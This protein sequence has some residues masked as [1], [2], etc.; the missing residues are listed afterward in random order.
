VIGCA[1]LCVVCS[2]DVGHSTREVEAGVEG[3]H[4]W[5]AI[6]S[7]LPSSQTHS[8][9]WIRSHGAGLESVHGEMWGCPDRFPFPIVLLE[10]FK[11]CRGIA[12]VFTLRG[13]NAPLVRVI[14]SPDSPEAVTADADGVIKIWDIRCQSFSAVPAVVLHSSCVL[15]CFPGCSRVFKRLTN[16]RKMASVMSR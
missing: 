9:R 1:G 8:L 16:R 3:A 2:E 12:A 7:V 10:D 6:C 14:A 13:H 11:S 5:R 4:Q 15:A